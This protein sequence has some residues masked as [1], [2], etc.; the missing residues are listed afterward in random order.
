MTKRILVVNV[1]YDCK[2]VAKTNWKKSFSTNIK[3]FV[4]HYY[5][6]EFKIEDVKTFWCEFVYQAMENPFLIMNFC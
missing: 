1:V 4:C 5:E 6:R 3:I 2:L